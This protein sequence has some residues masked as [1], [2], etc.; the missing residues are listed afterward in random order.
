MAYHDEAA[1]QK[2]VSENRIKE[3]LDDN[4]DGVA[5]TGKLDGII[6]TS[7]AEVFSY[8]AERY[9]TYA[10]SG[11]TPSTTNA[12]VRKLAATLTAIAIFGRR[13]RDPVKLRERAEA[14][15]QAIR[16]GLNSLG[17]VASSRLPGSTTEDR[18]IEF[19]ERGPMRHEGEPPPGDDTSGTGNQFFDQPAAAEENS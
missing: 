4:R 16:D 18:L 17:T 7:D 6:E 10:P 11:L 12:M 9:P 5:D 13:M 1:V 15:L 8:L 2:V 3:G 19:R 14:L